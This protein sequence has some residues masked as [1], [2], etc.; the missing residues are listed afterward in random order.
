MNFVVRKKLYIVI[1]FQIKLQ[2][3]FEFHQFIHEYVFWFACVRIWSRI[4]KCIVCFRRLF[5]NFFKF[6]LCWVFV[7][8]C[9]PYLVTVSLLCVAVFLVH[10]NK[11]GFSLQW[12]LL[13]QSLGSC[14]Q[15]SVV[16]A[17][18]LSSCALQA[19]ECGH[20]SWVSYRVWA[21]L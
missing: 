3:L 8:V 13:L 2:A 11:N 18:G 9:R 12:L 10:K 1:F 20:S 16:A 17:A 5:L 6:L 7:A 4:S 14:T 19:V 15:A 21:K